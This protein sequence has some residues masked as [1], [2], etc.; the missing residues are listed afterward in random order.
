MQTRWGKSYQRQRHE[1][2]GSCH[3]PDLHCRREIVAVHG[4][5][6]PGQDHTHV[7]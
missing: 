1:A 6:H 5:H 7:R 4:Y 2:M 3:A